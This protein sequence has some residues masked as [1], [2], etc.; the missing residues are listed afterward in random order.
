M[1]SQVYWSG[2]FYDCLEATSPGETPAT[3]PAKWRKVEVP[4]DC[5][6]FVPQGALGLLM[7]GDGQTDK[8]QA[9]ERRAQMLLDEAVIAMARNRSHPA[10]IQ[11]VSR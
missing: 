4:R 2:N 3:A 8:R 10:L 11:V 6:R 1:A 9:A 5:L 7:D